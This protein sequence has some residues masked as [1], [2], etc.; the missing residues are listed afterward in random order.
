MR[1][2]K[3]NPLLATLNHH[4]IVESEQVNDGL[5]IA[6]DYGSDDDE[7]ALAKEVGGEQR[8]DDFLYVAVLPELEELRELALVFEGFGACLD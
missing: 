2:L 7:A 3:G 5:G 6:G 8:V 1:L 4:E